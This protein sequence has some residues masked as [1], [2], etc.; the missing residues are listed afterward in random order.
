LLQPSFTI[1]AQAKDDY[2][3]FNAIKELR[4]QLDILDV[5]MPTGSGTL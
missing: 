4:P 3:A 1:V 2:A 5:S